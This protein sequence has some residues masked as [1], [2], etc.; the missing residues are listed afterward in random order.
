MAYL[1][2]LLLH[3][4]C[5]RIA[6]CRLKL[7]YSTLCILFSALSVTTTINN[8][9]TGIGQVISASE[10]RFP[11]HGHTTLNKHFMR[12]P[13]LA[14]SFYVL[15]LGLSLCECLFC[16]C[17]CVCSLVRSYRLKLNTLHLNTRRC[18]IL[19]ILTG[20]MCKGNCDY[21]T[22]KPNPSIWFS[23]D[24]KIRLIPQGHPV[25]VELFLHFQIN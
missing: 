19:M 7:E 6:S 17:V 20:F 22:E 10:T 21:C 24:D 13:F 11:I 1:L 15:A 2:N 9:R 14:R 18:L 3:Q 16:M 23:N 12:A 8:E 4:N 5:Y 25:S